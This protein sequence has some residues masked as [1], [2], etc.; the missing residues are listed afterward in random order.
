MSDLIYSP[1][2]RRIYVIDEIDD[3]P[4]ISIIIDSNGEITEEYWYQQYR[5]ETFCQ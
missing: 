3:I 4:Q 1:G 5:G 2:Y